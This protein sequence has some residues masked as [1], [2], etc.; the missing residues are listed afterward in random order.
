MIF[1]RC[2]LGGSIGGLIGAVVWAAI[3]YAGY[4]VGIVAWGIGFLVGF[5][6]RAAAGEEVGW[7][8]GILAVLIALGSVVAG[9]YMAVHML[10]DHHFSDAMNFKI[11]DPMIMV[12]VFAEEVQE[13]LTKAGKP[14]PEPALSPENNATTIEQHYAPAVWA[15]AKRRWDALP[16][17]QQAARTAEHEQE[18]AKLMGALTDTLQSHARSEGFRQ[19]F[20]LFDLL[21]G[22]LAAMTAFRLGSGAVGGD[23]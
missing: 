18:T 11:D 22:A 14:V 21:W 12:S 13:E 9:K 20:S 5:G 19:S 16:P 15:E 4:E 1:L 17:D 3:G 23:E 7:M 6:V 10:V 2:L 8:P